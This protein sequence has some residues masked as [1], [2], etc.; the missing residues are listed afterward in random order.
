MSNQ[1]VIIVGAGLAGLSCAIELR[2]AGFRP[3]VLEQAEEPG[4]RIRSDRKDG[5]I[6]DRGFQLLFTAYPEAQRLLDLSRLKIRPFL[7]A[8]R[9]RRNG[10]FYDLADPL[11]VPTK[12]IETALSPI[13]TMRD[14]WL[15]QR[16]R[17]QL[18]RS[19]VEQIFSGPDETTFVRLKTFGFSDGFIDAFFRPFFGGVFLERRLETSSRMFHFVFKMLVKGNA[20]LPELGMQSIP[21]QLVDYLSPDT[22]LYGARVVSV[23]DPTVFLDDGRE[24]V[25]RAIVLAGPGPSLLSSAPSLSFHGTTCSYF[26]AP[27]PPWSEA[28][29]VVNGEGSSPVNLVA[30]PSNVSPLYA[31]PGRA[32]I[33]VSSVGIVGG[34]AGRSKLLL[35]LREWL[36]GVVDRWE[37][38]AT[39]DIPAALPSFLPG[40]RGTA[41]A[42]EGRVFQCGDHTSDPSINGALRS[43]REVAAL[44]AARL[45]R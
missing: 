22:I 38:L 28:I 33:S 10:R 23:Q 32:L 2:R 27:E 11:R 39:Y 19:T 42:V 17:W 13:A 9:I 34:G 36:G 7:P 40:H 37:H 24:F 8:V 41:G 21:E 43:G 25:G 35:T 14:K 3:L 6:L 44:V 15:V 4:G 18:S 16:L 20:G 31:P 12:S 1:D 26:S 29:V 45:G 30:V 5:Y